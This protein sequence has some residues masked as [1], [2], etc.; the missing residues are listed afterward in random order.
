MAA[1]VKFE[2]CEGCGDCIETCPCGAIELKESKAVI[3][4]ELCA[5]SALA[6][7]PARPTR[8]RWSSLGRSKHR[9][10]ANTGCNAV[11]LRASHVS[12]DNVRISADCAGAARSAFSFSE[13][14][15]GKVRPRS[16]RSAGNRP[17]G[18]SHR[19][20]GRSVREAALRR[21]GRRVHSVLRF[22]GW[23]PL[24]RHCAVSLITLR[25]LRATGIVAGECSSAACGRLRRASRFVT[26]LSVLLFHNM[27]WQSEENVALA[28]GRRMG[29]PFRAIGERHGRAPGPVVRHFAR[30]DRRVDA[31]RPICE[32]SGVG[33]GGA[34]RTG[35]VRPLDMAKHRRK[36]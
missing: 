1:I 36:S 10:S 16:R 35:R 4:G 8:S 11:R 17:G 2:K 20:P 22:P 5:D 29:P 33:R 19:K 31:C 7:I 9:S 34:G 23:K 13:G 25:G 26:P 18:G 24:L 6:S 27:K 32:R 14:R 15:H 21:T 12:T 30:E 28:G 3:D